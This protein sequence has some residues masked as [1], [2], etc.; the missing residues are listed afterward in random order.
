MSASIVCSQSRKGRVLPLRA[1]WDDITDLDGTVGDDHAVDQQ[2]E[3]CPLPVEICCSQ[4]FLDTPAE[5]LSMS[6]QPGCLVLALGVVRE[7][8][9]L[10]LQCQQTGVGVAP[11]TLVLGQ[12]HHAS[13]GGLGE[14]L[15]VLAEGWPATP[16][17]GPGEI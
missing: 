5:R 7:V 8:Q 1:G 16:H 2:F 14:P 3:Q 6:G 4:A 11:A 17:A 9:L 12:R 15:E 13:K 10:T